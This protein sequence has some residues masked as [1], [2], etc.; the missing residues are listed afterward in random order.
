MGFAVQ[1]G[2][3]WNSPT[4]EYGASLDDPFEKNPTATQALAVKRL[5]PEIKVRTQH[6]PIAY[7]PFGAAM[8]TASLIC[9]PGGHLPKGGV[10]VYRNLIE[11]PGFDII[12]IAN[13]GGTACG[14]KQSLRHRV[15]NG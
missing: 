5:I 4:G 10:P 3:H 2:H 8:L 15:L 12:D 11:G 9:Q 7:Y 1:L 13:L 6:S 14:A